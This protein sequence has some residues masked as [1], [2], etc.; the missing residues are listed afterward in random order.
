M[1]TEDRCEITPC[2][3]D[4]CSEPGIYPQEDDEG[5]FMACRFHVDDDDL[6]I[7]SPR[8]IRIAVLV[9]ADELAR[10]RK[11]DLVVAAVQE[12][13]GPH[14]AGPANDPDWRRYCD[15]ANDGWNACIRTIRKAIG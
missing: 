13:T 9:D 11:I 4:R 12:R 1:S 3:A 14:P 7:P 10:L 6:T 8:V 2:F 15:H 5:T